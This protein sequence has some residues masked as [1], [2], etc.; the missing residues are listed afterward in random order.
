[1]GRR[2]ILIVC[3]VYGLL[4]SQSAR[5]QAAPPNFAPGPCHFTP[6]KGFIAGKNLTC[7]MLRVPENPAIIGGR[8]IKV[9]VAIFQ[10][11]SA[12]RQSNPVVFLQG[13]PGG[14]IVHDL[15][16]AISRLD[17]PT[18]MGDHDLILIDQ[19]GTG[20]SKPALN[21]PGV[22]A[23][24]AKALQQNASAKQQTAM[25]SLAIQAC[26]ARLSARGID[27]SAYNTVN[28]AADIAD[29]RAALNL[30]PLDLY[31]V[32]YGTR[33]AL[34]VMQY[35]PSDI[36]SA[37]LDSILTRQYN[38]FT[39]AIVAEARAF[40]Q[41][42]TGCEQAPKCHAKYP[43]L[44]RT[45]DTLLK[46]L[47]AH[48]LR[49]RAQVAGSKET[50]NVQLNGDAFAEYVRSAMYDTPLISSL[51]K[52]IAIIARG[53][54]LGFGK[55]YNHAKAAAGSNA[56]GT[57]E[58][59][60]CA[61]DAQFATLQSIQASVLGLPKAIRTYTA[62]QQRGQL[63]LCKLWNVAPAVQPQPQLGWTDI[64]TLLLGGQ[65][66]PITPPA[67]V[68]ATQALLPHSYGFVFPNSGHGVFLTS[69]CSQTVIN[70]FYN[71]PAAQPDGSCVAALKSPFS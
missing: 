34:A 23:A 61:E 16:S 54:H 6:G 11:P 26:R 25:E 45:F 60:T 44:K 62:K 69:K 70:A 57:Y 55:V 21:C 46:H 15:G 24:L 5:A 29:L 1:M 22:D 51:P 20:L 31:G 7:G 53:V 41:L 47:N 13:G 43:H 4:G 27:L 19:R 14:A 64:P 10:T 71:D 3:F 63:A 2:L 67:N 50:Y 18:I 42:F 17:A 68:S 58:S 32:S 35:V 39:D 30:P 12:N 8:Q 37:V 56:L 38:I 40:N 33:V 59:V 48:P 65:Y 66:D 52:I 9:A 28:D 36:H 49:F